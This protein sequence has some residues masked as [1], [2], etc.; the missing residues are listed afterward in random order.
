MSRYNL[1]F[2]KSSERAAVAYLEQEGYEILKINYRTKLGE[3]DIIA[4][5]SGII[6]FV[7]VKARSSGNFG[8][9]KEALNKHKQ[10][11]ISRSALH[12]LKENQIFDKSCRFDILSI[13]QDSNKQSTFELIKDAFSLDEKY[14]Y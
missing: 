3:I 6:C 7:E 12:Y 9:P 2:G 4:K 14:S 13:I 1:N 8:H 5:N 11:N 10:H